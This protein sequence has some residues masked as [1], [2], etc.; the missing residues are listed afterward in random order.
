VAKARET[1]AVNV[2]VRLRRRPRIPRAL[3]SPGVLT[4]T[5]TFPDEK[6]DELARLFVL[7]VERSRLPHVLQKL[8]DDP[9]IEFAEEAGLKRLIKRC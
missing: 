6:D 1:V 2:K 4:A 9:G 8:R 5:Q 7:K 3:S